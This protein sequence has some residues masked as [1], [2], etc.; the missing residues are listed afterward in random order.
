MPVSIRVLVGMTGRYARRQV[1][2][3]TDAFWRRHWRWALP[4]V[5]GAS[6][7]A[8]ALGLLI[9]VSLPMWDHSFKCKPG[10]DVRREC[11]VLVH[12]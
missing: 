12:G 4:P 3:R 1:E 11:G 8:G 6:V 7:T 9:P 10:L 5:F 2:L